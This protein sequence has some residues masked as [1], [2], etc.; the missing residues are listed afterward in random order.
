M[1]PAF[2][3]SSDVLD[4]VSTFND[5]ILVV[6]DVN[7]RLDRP[8]ASAFRQF[9]NTLTAHGLSCRVTVATHDHI[10]I[11]DHL[12]LPPVEVANKHRLPSRL[13]SSRRGQVGRGV[14]LTLTSFA[15]H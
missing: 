15:L 2:F 9:T 5:P 7:T 11:R 6:G 12:P 3:T 13:R 14:I 10:A 8:D 1:T 4:R